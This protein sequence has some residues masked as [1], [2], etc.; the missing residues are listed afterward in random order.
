MNPTELSDAE[1]VAEIERFY[2]KK[3][4][5]QYGL[6]QEAA[7][8][9]TAR[10]DTIARVTAAL[11]G[12]LGQAGCNWS[13]YQPCTERGWP[14]DR[15]CASCKA[16]NA[17]DEALTPT[18]PEAAVP[19]PVRRVKCRACFHQHAPG[20][21]CESRN[22]LLSGQSA[23]DCRDMQ[24]STQPEA[25]EPAATATLRCIY[26]DTEK[27]CANAKMCLGSLGSPAQP[28]TAPPETR[29]AA[30]PVNSATFAL[31][32]DALQEMTMH[33]KEPHERYESARDAINL[34]RHLW[35]SDIEARAA[36]VVAK[37]SE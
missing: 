9:L 5:L 16:I 17:A 11:K 37:G 22:T 20:V 12:M 30:R 31:A 7:R 14:R 23:C 36:A 15:W 27:E 13:S 25:S 21:A 28:P 34:L 19:K 3:F 32:V 2:S 10:N 29:A 24:L 33:P 6:A 18:Q 26:C 4:P 8:R 35:M 1:L